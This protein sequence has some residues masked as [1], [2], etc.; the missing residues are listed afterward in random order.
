MNI[1]ALK[2]HVIEDEI[3]IRELMAL[4]LSRQG[5]Q[6]VESGSSEEALEKI[7]LRRLIY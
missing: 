2:V 3:E 4:H 5:Y 1:R 6:V 7:K